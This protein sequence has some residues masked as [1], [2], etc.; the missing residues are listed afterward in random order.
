MVL[1]IYRLGNRQLT[2]IVK[3]YKWLLGE[4][5]FSVWDGSSV[6]VFGS[7]IVMSIGVVEMVCDLFWRC[8]VNPKEGCCDRCFQG[9]IGIR[10]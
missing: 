5:V 10:Q 6:G 9:F 4:A 8:R 7:R 1:G 2:G 3:G